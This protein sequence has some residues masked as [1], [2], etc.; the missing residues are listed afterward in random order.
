MG[1]GLQLLR[2]NA[3][4]LGT[5][6]SGRVAPRSEKRSGTST[7]NRAEFHHRAALAGAG[8]RTDAR[9]GNAR[10]DQGRRAREPLPPAQAAA[11]AGVRTD[12][13]GARFP[14]VLAARLRKSARR[15]GHRL[16]RPQS[17]QAGP[18]AESVRSVVDGRWS[19]LTGVLPR[20]RNTKR[21][22]SR[23]YRI[24]RWSLAQQKN[25]R[26]PSPNSPVSPAQPG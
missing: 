9:R 6:C 10:E 16:H 17:P 11:R 4:I 25:Q 19:G 3:D 14:P 8:W 13:T 18:E 15:V 21:P 7:A 22:R 26:A 5:P 1:R 2:K 20:R 12:K 23:K 24:Q